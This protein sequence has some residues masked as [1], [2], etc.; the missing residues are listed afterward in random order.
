MLPGTVLAGLLMI[1]IPEL[2]V[3]ELT[4]NIWVLAIAFY[5]LGII[6]SRISSII[7]EPLLVWSKII[8]KV[9]HSDFTKAEMLDQSRKVTEISRMGAEYRSYISTFFIVILLKL[10]MLTPFVGLIIKNYAVWSFL[11][12]GIILFTISFRKQH[13]YTKSRVKTILDNCHE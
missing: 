6:N 5:F 12:F 1:C 3:L 2:N 11:V 9:P 7:I 8:T 10:L 4:N 13:N